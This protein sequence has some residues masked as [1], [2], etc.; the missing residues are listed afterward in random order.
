M[1][2]YRILRFNGC[3]RIAPLRELDQQL[4]LVPAGYRSIWQS[5]D[6][7]PANYHVTRPMW[8]LFCPQSAA[9]RALRSSRRNRAVSAGPS[10]AL[11]RLFST[12]G[13]TR[14]RRPE[15]YL[16]RAL[17]SR[18]CA[19]TLASKWRKARQI[20][21]S[22]QSYTRPIRPMSPPRHNARRS[23]CAGR[24]RGVPLSLAG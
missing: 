15:D 21:A 7:P 4:C 13:R 18:F 24:H 1:T 14:R 11:R 2:G 17:R 12:P 20:V 19:P 9:R 22:P 5:G 3:S 23:S 8:R 10:S 16:T 6:C